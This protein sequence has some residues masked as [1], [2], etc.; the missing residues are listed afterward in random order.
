MARSSYIYVVFKDEKLI[1]A[2]TVKY[3]MINSL[4]DYAEKL[5]KDKYQIYRL[6][7]GTR[8]VTPREPLNITEEIIK[9]EYGTLI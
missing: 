7:D 2:F 8:H 6:D 4:P 5:K 9:E 1:R 3:E